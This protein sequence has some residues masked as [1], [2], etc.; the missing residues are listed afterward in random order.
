MIPKFS[1]VDFVSFYIEIPVMIVMFTSWL[2]LKRFTRPA[3]RL[4]ARDDESRSRVWHHLDVVDIDTV[5]LTQDEYTD[6]A[7]DKEEDEE[8]R[9]RISG[10]RGLWWRLYYWI[11]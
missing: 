10:P 11:V 4:L 6:E 3:G 8:R 5:D 9:G 1:P 2:M 7:E